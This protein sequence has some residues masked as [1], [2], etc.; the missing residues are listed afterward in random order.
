MLLAF[1][2]WISLALREEL[3]FRGYPSF[4]L[5]SAWG[6]S[7]A[8]AVIAVLFTLEHAAGGWHWWCW[9][10]LSGLSSSVWQRSGRG[11]LLCLLAF[12]LPSISVNGLWGKRKDSRDHSAP[13]WMQDTKVRL[14]RSAMLPT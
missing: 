3:A 2:G 4:R 13:S 14:S 1:A 5:E 8:L 6:I 10:H 7:T 11:G 9:D 12:I